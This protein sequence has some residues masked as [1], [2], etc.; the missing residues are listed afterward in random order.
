MTV[1]QWLI[2]YANYLSPYSFIRFR[3]TLEAYFKLPIYPGK[4]DVDRTV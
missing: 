1:L 4:Q 2:P 3:R